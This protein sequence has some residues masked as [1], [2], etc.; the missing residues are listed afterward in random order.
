MTLKL[1][2]KVI[3]KVN[4][5]WSDFLLFLNSLPKRCHLIAC[6]L[7]SK[8]SLIGHWIFPKLFSLPM[9]WCLKFSNSFQVGER[10]SGCKYSGVLPLGS[11]GNFHFNLSLSEPILGV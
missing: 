4:Q 2:A 5:S 6:I 8:G 9:T 3:I 11:H 1:L 7:G 10:L